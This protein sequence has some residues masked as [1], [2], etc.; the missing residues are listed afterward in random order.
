VGGKVEK[1]GLG[2]LHNNFFDPKSVLKGV[3]LIAIEA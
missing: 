2:T 3:T 1:G